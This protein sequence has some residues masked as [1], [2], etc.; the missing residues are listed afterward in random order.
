MALGLL[1]MKNAIG[2][3]GKFKITADFIQK[4]TEAPKDHNTIFFKSTGRL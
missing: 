3:K 1:W 4:I 2:L